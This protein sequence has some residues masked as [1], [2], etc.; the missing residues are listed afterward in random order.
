M[1]N[2]RK[3]AKER[4][5]GAAK[6]LFAAKGFDSASVDEIAKHAHVNKALIYYYFESKDKLLEYQFCIFPYP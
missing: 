4:I 6:K 5:I 2:E 3:D 1:K